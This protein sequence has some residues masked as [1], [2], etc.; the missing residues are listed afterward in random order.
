M[1]R[2]VLTLARVI[3]AIVHMAQTPVMRMRITSKKVKKKEKSP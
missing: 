3:L 2:S 1:T